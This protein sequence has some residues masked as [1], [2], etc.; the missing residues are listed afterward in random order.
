MTLLSLWNYF[1]FGALILSSTIFVMLLLLGHSYRLM[2]IFFA[3]AVPI[4]IPLMIMAPIFAIIIGFSLVKNQKNRRTAIRSIILWIF[5]FTLSLLSY[6]GAV[7]TKYQ[8]SASDSFGNQRYYLIKFFYIDSYSY[9]LYTCEPLSLFCR[10]S[11][12]YIGIPFQ[13]QPIYL[14]YSLKTHK[15]YIQN[16]DQT[17]QISDQ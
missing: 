2:C 8:V 10:S 5:V 16:A 6:L 7:F 9:K 11:S 17:I 14:R 4:T 15:V 12:E 1:N 3:V 13:K